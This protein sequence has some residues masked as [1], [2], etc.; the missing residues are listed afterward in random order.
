MHYFDTSALV[1]LYIDEPGS[2]CLDELIDAYQ[3]DR[4]AA[5]DLARIE[6]RSALRLRE[7][8]GDLDSAD[9]VAALERLDKDWNQLYLVQPC[10]S[11]V[12]EEAIVILD[13]QPLRAYDAVQLAGCVVLG[14]SIT[15]EIVF[16]SADAALVRAAHDEGLHTFNPLDEDPN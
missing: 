4:F 5:L 8:T 3:L 14:R 9:V 10:A 16:V 11:S 15:T 1:K 13:R 2:G 7:R 6:F 12:L